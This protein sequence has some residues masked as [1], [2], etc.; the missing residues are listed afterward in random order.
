MLLFV[1]GLM[2]LWT[3]IYMLLLH[4]GISSYPLAFAHSFYLFIK[5]VVFWG[6][7][8]SFLDVVISIYILFVAIGVS[9][10]IAS[11]LFAGYLFQKSFF[12]LK[13]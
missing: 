1:L 6:N 10:I 5:G 4:L 7:V 11:L 9:H 3:S 13:H 12:S 2:D 8:Y